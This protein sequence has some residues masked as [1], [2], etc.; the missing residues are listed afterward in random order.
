M[1]IV[2]VTYNALFCLAI[3]LAPLGAIANV[4]DCNDWKAKRYKN[5]D[6]CILA[7]DKKN[8]KN[9][10]EKK[11]KQPISVYRNVPSNSKAKKEHKG[12]GPGD[13]HFTAKPSASAAAAAK[14]NGMG[15]RMPKGTYSHTIKPGEKYKTAKTAGAHGNKKEILVPRKDV[16]KD[17]SSKYKEYKK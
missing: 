11:A 8:E 5:Y 7:V 4:G 1:R 10:Q 15:S 13:Y 3:S 2:L 6:Q 12:K 17:K 16:R 14:E 9:A